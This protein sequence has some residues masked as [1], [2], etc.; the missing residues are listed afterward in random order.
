ME[1]NSN[2]LCLRTSFSIVPSAMS[3]LFNS[4]S[5]ASV[6]VSAPVPVI[7]WLGLTAVTVSVPTAWTVATMF[8]LST[9]EPPSELAGTDTSRYDPSPVKALAVGFSTHAGSLK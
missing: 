4:R 3:N 5:Y 6:S 2:A 7:V 9:E 8:M 1:L